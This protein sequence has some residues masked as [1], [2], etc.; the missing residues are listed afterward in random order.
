MKT[1]LGF[2]FVASDQAETQYERRKLAV[3]IRGL[4]SRD[5]RK[6]ELLV[7]APALHRVLDLYYWS[8]LYI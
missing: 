6:Y 5:T 8:L 4:D 2:V 1:Y 3:K 7:A